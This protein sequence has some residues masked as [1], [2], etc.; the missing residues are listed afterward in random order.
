MAI[1]LPLLG[2]HCAVV[3]T[4]QIVDAAGALTDDTTAATITGVLEAASFR[5][6]T[7]TEEISPITSLIENNV[8][9]QTG[10]EMTVREIMDRRASN[11]TTSVGPLLA[12]LAENLASPAIVKFVFTRGSNVWTGYGVLSDYNEGPM[13]KGKNV[14]EMTLTGVN[15]GATPT[16]TP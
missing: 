9:L 1:P 8:L 14:A 12:Q 7:T 11:L 13:A 5:V 4:R 2:Q 6:R 15:N 10:W 3:L 16:Y